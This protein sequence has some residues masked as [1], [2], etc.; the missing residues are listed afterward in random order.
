MAIVKGTENNTDRFK[1]TRKHFGKVQRKHGGNIS[2]TG[3]SL[4]GRLAQH[5]SDKYKVKG[6]SFNGGAGLSTIGEK[7]N[8]LMRNIRKKGDIVSALKTHNE[9]TGNDLVVDDLDQGVLKAHGTDDLL[10]KED[11]QKGFGNFF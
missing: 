11:L 9:T 2:V 3:H 7:E 1:N 10:S 8:P 4:A 5:I 6:Y